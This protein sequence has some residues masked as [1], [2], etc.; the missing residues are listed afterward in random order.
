MTAQR[1]LKLIIRSRMS[2]TGESYSAARAQIIRERQRPEEPEQSL[3]SP[4]EV[5]T[6]APVPAEPIEVAVIKVTMSSARIRPVGANADGTITLRSSGASE[7]IPGQI[8]TV[9]LDRRWSHAGNAYASGKVLGACTDIAKLKLEPLPLEDCG[10]MNMRDGYE[11]MEPSDPCFS[12]W[13]KNTAKP[14]PAFEMHKIA[15]DA[16]ADTDDPDSAP[17][18]DAAELFESGDRTGARKLLM[19]VLGED[20]R[21]IDAHG[22]LGN[23]VFDFSPETA[24]LHYEIGVGIGELSL[25]PNFTGYLPWGMLYNRPFLRCLHGLGLCLW[26]LDRREDAERVFERILSLNPNDNQG[27]RFCLHAVQRGVAWAP[28]DAF[29]HVEQGAPANDQSMLH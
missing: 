9:R 13:R 12:L 8:A 11:P 4:A 29:L 3:F 21:C 23:H 18:C 10:L 1:D 17:V 22:H 16:L 24:M 27:V 5:E 25:G 28:D 2:K 20:L 6:A 15:W 19:K 14:R 7:L 26:R